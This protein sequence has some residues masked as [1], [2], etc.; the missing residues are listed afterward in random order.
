MEV[1]GRSPESFTEGWK[2]P[3]RRE[4]E[5]VTTRERGGEKRMCVR[6]E[7]GEN[8]WEDKAAAD[9]RSLVWVLR[10]QENRVSSTWPAWGCEQQ[11]HPGTTQIGRAVRGWYSEWRLPYRS[12]G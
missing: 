3:W 1:Y 10:E 6:G 12:C 8:M 7:E 4:R 5:D 9:V 2:K 11:N